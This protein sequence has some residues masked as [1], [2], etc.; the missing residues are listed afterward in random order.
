MKRKV[1]ESTPEENPTASPEPLP[2]ESA[3]N[4]ADATQISEYAAT[5]AAAEVPDTSLMQTVES[6]AEAAVEEVAAIVEPARRRFGESLGK[7]VYGTCYYAAYSVVYGSLSLAR[8]VP[9]DNLVGRA[10]RDGA[11]DARSA[12]E[13]QPEAIVNDL[14]GMDEPA[15]LG[16]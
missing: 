1:P 4:E 10:I 8:L 13:R 16:A 12:V 14:A 6:A 2:Q 5:H 3:V 9:M 7:A 11:A 15:P